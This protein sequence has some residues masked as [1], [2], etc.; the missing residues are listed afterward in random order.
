MAKVQTRILEYAM[1]RMAKIFFSR[2][3]TTPN[4]LT[5]ISGCGAGEC[6]L[7]GGALPGVCAHFGKP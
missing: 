3:H 6:P 7:S 1:S 5:S 4:G 2:I